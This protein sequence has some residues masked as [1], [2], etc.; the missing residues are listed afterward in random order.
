MHPLQPIAPA[1]CTLLLLLSLLGCGSPEAVLPTA[2]LAPPPMHL[3]P[4]TQ[5]LT[6][7]V[8]MAL[9]PD[10]RVLVSEKNTGYVRLIDAAFHLQPQPVLDVAV[11]QASERGLLGIA[12]HPDF[13]HNGYVYIAYVASTSTQ[14]S[15]DPEAVSDMR[16]ARFRL[17]GAQAEDSLQTL[18]T[19]PARPGP[20]HQGGCILFGPDGKLYISLGELNR[21]A[22]FN[23]QLRQNLRGKILRYN[24]DGSMPPDNPWGADNSIYVYGLRNSFGFAFALQGNGLFVSDNGPDGHDKL[25]RAF[26]GDNLGWPLIWGIPDT[27]H[28]RLA[29]W[30]LGKRYRHPLWE[31]FADHVVP[32]AVQVVPSDLYGAAMSGRVLMSTFGQGH[33]LQF[34]LDETRHSII[35]GIG[36]FL[37][38]LSNIVDL[39]FDANG[40]LYVLTINALYRVDPVSG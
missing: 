36:T 20:Y 7:A 6:F 5:G 32:T 2:S 16:V 15:D 18:I 24:D 10:G 1:C 9:L 34:T 26:P 23:S 29:A 12:I 22:N 11:N 37:E 27:W 33:I 38:G 30:F 17:R 39:Q 40:R 28:E 3:T 25:S 31:S 4:L 13:A 35:T 19:L 14:D 8:K 21:H